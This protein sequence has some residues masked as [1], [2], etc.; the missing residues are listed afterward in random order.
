MKSNTPVQIKNTPIKWE[1]LI[2][3]VPENEDI[4]LQALKSYKILDTLPEPDFD[5]LTE[6]AAYIC[7]TP[8]ASIALI[9]SDRLWFKSRVGFDLE[10]KAEVISETPRELSFC[11]FTILEKDIFEIEDTLT[12]PFS[13]NNP[14]VTGKPEIRFYA[15]IPLENAEGLNIGTLCV[16]D[17]KSRRLDAKQKRALKIIANQVVAQLELRSMLIKEKEMGEV[18]SRFIS[19]ISHQFR[20]PLSVIK[21]NIELIDILQP[22]LMSAPNGLIK[23]CIGRIQDEVIQMTELMDNVLILNQL[24]RNYMRYTPKLLD[25]EKTGLKVIERLE[26]IQKDGRKIHLLTSGKK[27]LVSLDKGQLEI[28]LTNLLSNALKYSSD[29]P[30]LE[31]KYGEESVSVSIT[32]KGI[33]IPEEDL[34]EIFKPF[35]RSDNVAETR[36]TG[37]GLTIAKELTEMNGGS[38]HVKSSMIQKKTTFYVD[39]QTKN[40]NE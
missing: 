19:L 7:D 36:G 10:P 23:K 17:Q 35:F 4:R 9:D 21:S 11:Q 2:P 26:Q 18:K 16:I 6:L 14:Y 15:G 13:K 1:K 34:T 39:F 27:M 3:P 20:T 33:G 8:I 40:D 38:I 31:I 24:N 30:E 5:S 25:L 22:D 12:S 28:I 29:D 32:D 37:L